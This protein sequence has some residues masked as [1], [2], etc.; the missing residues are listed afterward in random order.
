[1]PA[2]MARLVQSNPD[3]LG[4]GPSKIEGGAPALHVRPEVYSSNH[5]HYPRAPYEFFHFHEMAEG[6]SHA[7]LSP[8]DASLVIERGWSERHGLSGRALGFPSTYVMI[9]APRDEDEVEI[10]TMI[11]KAAA[12]YALEGKMLN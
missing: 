10:I 11:A 4:I 9:F 5:A 6:S 7:I 3:L 12:R 1:M 2:S 8:A